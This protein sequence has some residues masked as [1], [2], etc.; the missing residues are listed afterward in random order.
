VISGV[1]HYSMT[2]QHQAIALDLQSRMT[3][4]NISTKMYN[5]PVVDVNGT[6]SVRPEFEAVLTR[7]KEQ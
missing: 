1:Q 6:L 3:A 4:A 5:L 7:Y 2:S